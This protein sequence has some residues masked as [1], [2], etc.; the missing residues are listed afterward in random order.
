VQENFADDDPPHPD[1]HQD[2]GSRLQGDD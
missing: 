1:R 2:A